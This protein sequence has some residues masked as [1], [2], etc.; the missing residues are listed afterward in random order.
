MKR[1]QRELAKRRAMPVPREVG[2]L[3]AF[4]NNRN[5][6]ESQEW[7]KWT[8]ALRALRLR[9]TRGFYDLGPLLIKMFTEP[10]HGSAF[11]WL[12]RYRDFDIR[13]CPVCHRFFLR[14]HG[15]QVYCRQQCQWKG[16]NRASALTRRAQRA[17]N[18]KYKATLRQRK[19]EAYMERKEQA[20]IAAMR[21]RK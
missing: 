17:G 16:T 11:E 12:F 5:E 13:A 6:S 14:R 1:E 10:E 4:V 20:A 19:V 21:T 2:R 9:F 15:R 18:R 3:L 7:L 8:L